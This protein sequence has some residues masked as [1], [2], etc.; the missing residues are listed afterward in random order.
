MSFPCRSGFASD[1]ARAGDG[2]AAAQL[3]KLLG[4]AGCP[5]A[6]M[7]RALMRALSLAL[8]IALICHGVVGHESNLYALR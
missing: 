3:A 2:F 4:A 6:H 1:Q 5:H 7:K 8:T